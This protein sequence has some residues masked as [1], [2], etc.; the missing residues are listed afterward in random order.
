MSILPLFPNPLY[1]SKSKE[2][3]IHESV[4]AL[5]CFFLPQFLM[6]TGLKHKLLFPKTAQM[7]FLFRLLNLF[8][9]CT[10][11]LNYQVSFQT[12]YTYLY[13]ERR[14]QWERILTP[15]YKWDVIK[16]LVYTTTYAFF[17]YF[18]M[19]IFRL[20][21]YP[22]VKKPLWVQVQQLKYFPSVICWLP[23]AREF[24]SLW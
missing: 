5:F 23:M 2:G 19:T 10:S 11:S 14:C 16:W 13:L 1:T 24:H 17:E 18:W 9:Q 3:E 6:V 7:I 12:R 20:I 15:K 21:N 8:P 22:K 4:T